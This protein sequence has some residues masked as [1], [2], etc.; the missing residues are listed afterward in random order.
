MKKQLSIVLLSI[1]PTLGLAQETIKVA[2]TP[3]PHAEMLEYAQSIAPKDF[4]IEILT[5]TDY[6]IP[7]LMLDSHEVDANFMQTLPYMKA[8]SA[9]N[10]MTLTSLGGI[11]I[12][13]LG[14][15]STKLK[16]IDELPHNAKVAIPNE[17]T[18]GGRALSLLHKHGVITLENPENIQ[19]SLSD[20]KDNPKNITF[21]ELESPMLTRSID[22]VDLAFINTNF[23]LD[24]GL[25]PTK[26]AII[27]EAKDAPYVNVLTVNAK[28]IDDPKALKL[29]EILTSDQMR[30]FIND[31][32][33]GS[34]VPAF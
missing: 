11:H 34:I 15:Y 26:D 4:T 21:I 12:E 29:L 9:D 1:L 13:P 17:A 27:L 16:S 25:I 31:Q 6:V 23:A 19:A 33:E 8:F 24:A 30:D 20:I 7:N 22:E 28:D 3:V 14:G 32:Y 5:V 2:A 18:N 10:N